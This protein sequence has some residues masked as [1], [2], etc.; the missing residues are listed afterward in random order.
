L[1]ALGINKEREEGKEKLIGEIRSAIFEINRL[2]GEKL[3][4]EDDYYSHKEHHGY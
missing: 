1:K 4:N 2:A 3:F